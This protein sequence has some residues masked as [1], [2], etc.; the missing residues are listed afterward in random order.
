MLVAGD[1]A[2][3]ADLPEVL[4]IVENSTRLNVVATAAPARVV[5]GDA[6]A[7]STTHSGGHIRITLQPTQG[8]G[9]I[10]YGTSIGENAEL[11]TDGTIHTS[12]AMV[13]AARAFTTTYDV[14]RVEV[15]A[16]VTRV[17]NQPRVGPAP[18]E[19]VD[20]PAGSAVHEL[21]CGFRRDP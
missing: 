11:R 10:A 19:P 8:R 1:G 3:P 9:G 6:A 18:P 21:R 15:V 14:E 7:R 4:A 13:I 16:G 2:E 17:A 20:K 5:I 12:Q